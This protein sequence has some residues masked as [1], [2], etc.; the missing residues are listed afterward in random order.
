MKVQSKIIRL[1]EMENSPS[2]MVELSLDLLKIVKDM[3]L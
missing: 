2:M 3:A 1:M